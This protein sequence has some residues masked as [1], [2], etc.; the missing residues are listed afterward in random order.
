MRSGT[1]PECLPQD[2]DSEASY[3]DDTDEDPSYGRRMEDPRHKSSKGQSED[4]KKRNLENGGSESVQ[5][6]DTTSRHERNLHHPKYY[7]Y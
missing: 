6:H 4:T 1:R 7:K 5:Y 2:D 3:T